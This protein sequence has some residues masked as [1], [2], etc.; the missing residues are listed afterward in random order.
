MCYP[1]ALGIAALVMSAA[2]TAASV[3]AQNSAARATKKSAEDAANADAA[4]LALQ[5]QQISDKGTQ[6]GLEIRRQA[7]LTRGTLLTALADT[8]IEGRS[9]LREIYNVTLKE[10]EAITAAESNVTAALMQN[11]ADLE[12]VRVQAEGRKRM[13]KSVNPYAAG[14]QIASSGV[15]GFASGYTMGKGLQSPTPTGGTG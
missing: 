9:P 3:A 8:G 15:Q 13:A 14:L 6:E 5:A 1:V 10:G 4:A 11:R 12:R 2:S 7:M